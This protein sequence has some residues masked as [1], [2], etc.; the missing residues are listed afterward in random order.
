MSRARK[1][2]GGRN[3]NESEVKQIKEEDKTFYFS[4]SNN[5]PQQHQQPVTSD[6]FFRFYCVSKIC[7]DLYE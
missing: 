2:I 4:P 1:G 3:G 6:I 5:L 7:Y